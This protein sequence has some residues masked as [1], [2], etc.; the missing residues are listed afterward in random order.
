MQTRQE[1][2]EIFFRQLLRVGARV[3]STLLVG[4]QL[5]TRT[6]GNYDFFGE[7]QVPCLPGAGRL[8]G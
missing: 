2:A 8:L 6:P 5:A 7:P 3:A 1:F 4:R